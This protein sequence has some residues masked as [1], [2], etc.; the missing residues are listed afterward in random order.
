MPAARGSLLEGH[1]VRLRAADE[2]GAALA[3]GCYAKAFD[4]V[5]RPNGLAAD[6]GGGMAGSEKDGL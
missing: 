2:G 5:A 3:D 1:H 4:A 6:D